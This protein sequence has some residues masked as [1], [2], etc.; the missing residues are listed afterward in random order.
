M[1]KEQEKAI[2]EIP[3][4]E[5]SGMSLDDVSKKLDILISLMTP[6]VETPSIETPSS[7]PEIAE[8]IVEEKTEPEKEESEE[9]D[10]P[11][12]DELNELQDFIDN[13]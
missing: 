1:D 13:Y 11:S 10:L 7:E 3:T 9:S 5:N 4:T 12:E 2:E 8:P 6:T